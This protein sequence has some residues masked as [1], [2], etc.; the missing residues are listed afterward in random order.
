M[1]TPCSRHLHSLQE[2]V[3]ALL[4]E[5][6]QLNGKV[7]EVKKAEARSDPRN[8]F[9]PYRGGGGYG[10]GMGGY[11]YGGMGGGMGFPEMGAGVISE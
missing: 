6:H 11:G 3:N 7:V 8:R 2:S 5:T 1:A 9:T 10:M 4:D